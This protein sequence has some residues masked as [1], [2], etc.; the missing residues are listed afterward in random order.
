M[1]ETVYAIIDN[2][3]HRS[4]TKYKFLYKTKDFKAFMQYVQDKGLEC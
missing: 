1:T 4:E 2:C 3:T